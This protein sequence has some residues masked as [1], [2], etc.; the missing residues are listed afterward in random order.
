M[1]VW[2]VAQTA[3]FLNG[4]RS[5]RLYAVYHLIVLRGLETVACSSWLVTTSRPVGR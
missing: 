3:R 1:A 2:T 4:I 5:H